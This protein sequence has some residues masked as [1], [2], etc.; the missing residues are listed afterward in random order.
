MKEINQIAV[1]GAGVMGCGVSL[2]LALKGY[3]VIL[4]DISDEVLEDAKSKIK[5]DYRMVKMMNRSLVTES[6]DDV[7]Q[8]ISFQL[9]YN[10]FNNVD[11][12]THMHHFR[13]V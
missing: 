8:K 6:L 9:T 4:K 2:N 12:W 3:S 10:N 7:L 13:L 11:F 1:I 5:S